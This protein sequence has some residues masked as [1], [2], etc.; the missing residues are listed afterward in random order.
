M[1]TIKEQ[2]GDTLRGIIDG[3]NTTY[4]SSYNFSSKDD[5]DIYIN[6][7]LS[8]EFS[9]VM[10]NQIILDNPLF[11]GDS[12]EVEYFSSV[13]MG[14]GADGGCPDTPELINVKPDIQLEEDLPDSITDDLS[15]MSFSETPDIEALLDE[16]VPKIFD[17]EEAD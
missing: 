14:G 13:L 7:V 4:F 10:P 12:L 2:Q 17:V 9:V 15:P 11:P 5:V 16:L 8:T 3:V 6:D 1:L